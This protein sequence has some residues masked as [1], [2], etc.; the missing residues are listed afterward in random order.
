M[1]YNFKKN[2]LI[3]MKILSTYIKAS[4]KGKH[5]VIWSLFENNVTSISST[6]FQAGLNTPPNTV[7]H[8]PQRVL[9]NSCN[10][11]SNVIGQILE[12]FGSINV[13]LLLQ[14]TPCEEV[15]C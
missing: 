2:T 12:S 6:G 10:T 9:W 13:H 14:V 5:C 3:E 8:F 11:S 4:Y 1:I 15:A 7:H